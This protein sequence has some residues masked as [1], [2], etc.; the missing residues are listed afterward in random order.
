[1]DVFEKAAVF[2]TEAHRG[3]LR[4][5]DG[6]PYILH[7]FEVAAIAG[8]MTAD[9]EVLAAAVLHDTV[10]DAG[11]SP[12]LI[13]EEF[14]ERVAL[15][16]AS[17]TEDKMPG[18]PKDQ[19]WRI[20][21]EES[22]DELSRA[23]DVGVKILWLSDKLANVRSFLRL[24]GKCGPGFWGQF[25]QSDPAQ[26]KWYYESVAELTKELSDTAAW[27]EYRDLLTKLFEGEKND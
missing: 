23:K 2:A 19:T 24:R 11:V 14:G 18:F 20:R 13:S 25:N 4:K 6:I 15:L 5:N 16:V 22:L 1:M 26:Q 3:E 17:E 8:T 12:D 21:K 27:R 9:R 7:P 10:E